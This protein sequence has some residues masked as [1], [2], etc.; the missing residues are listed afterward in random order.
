[1]AEVV[2]NDKSKYSNLYVVTYHKIHPKPPFQLLESS[3]FDFL[4][5]SFRY[6][7]NKNPVGPSNKSISKTRR[8][9]EHRTYQM[10]YDMTSY[11]VAYMVVLLCDL[12]QDRTQFQSYPSFQVGS[13]PSLTVYMPRASIYHPH[14]LC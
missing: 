3:S 10:F 14:P 12:P 5:K 9:T 13:C 6:L 4:R 7:Y 2:R 8:H 11:K 1:M